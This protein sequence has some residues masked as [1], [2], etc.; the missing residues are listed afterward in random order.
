M[1]S[2]QTAPEDNSQLTEDQ[3]EELERQEQD[4]LNKI[5]KN[6]ASNSLIVLNNLY[7]SYPLSVCRGISRSERSKNN[8]DSPTLTYGEVAY[9]SFVQIIQKLFTYDFPRNAKTGKFIDIGC[10]KGNLV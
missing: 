3:I 5:F 10:G 6:N 9:D 2:N 8:Y 4:K 1:D 7:N